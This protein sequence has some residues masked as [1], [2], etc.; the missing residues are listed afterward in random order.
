MYGGQLMFSLIQSEIKKLIKQKGLIGLFIVGIIL[1]VYQ[2]NQVYQNYNERGF[3]ENEYANEQGE[4]FSP[5][6]LLLY[7]D[8]VIHRYQGKVTPAIY[9][10]IQQ[11]Y[12]AHLKQY[13]NM[14]IDEKKMKSIYGKDYQDC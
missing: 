1:G 8:E 11:D 10:Q 12:Q 13:D 6:E 14:V 4:L 5:T 3:L 9:A 2:G 7:V